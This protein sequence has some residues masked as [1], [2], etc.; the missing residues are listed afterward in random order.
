MSNI[1]LN[2][3]EELIEKA[4]DNALAKRQKPSANAELLNFVTKPKKNASKKRKA[5]KVEPTRI[6]LP[7]G[8]QN[9]EGMKDLRRKHY[10]QARAEGL[11]YKQ[12]NEAGLN[13]VRKAL[14]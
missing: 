7:E 9:V 1:T 13:A 5:K 10:K 12:A 14:A 2:K 6:E 8:W 11:G 3:L 4:V